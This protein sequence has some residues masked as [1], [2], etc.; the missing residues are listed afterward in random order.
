MKI[1]RYVT[2]KVINF[3][4]QLRRIAA[5]KMRSNLVV[6]VENAF[7]STIYPGDDKISLDSE[8][9]EFRGDWKALPAEVVRYNRS[10]I[11]FMTSIGTAYYLPAFLLLCLRD[12]ISADSLLDS[13]VYRLNTLDIMNPKVVV[14]YR[15]KNVT[16]VATYLD[17]EQTK[18]LVKFFRLY[19]KLYPDDQLDEK[20]KL[21]IKDAENC[22]VQILVEKQNEIAK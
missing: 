11:G 9:D 1:R 2:Y 22:W 21:H 5:N 13:I 12:P 8:A 16:E 20:F 17:V 18:V 10:G 3:Y 14:A 4:R 6:E 15:V 7:S 19:L